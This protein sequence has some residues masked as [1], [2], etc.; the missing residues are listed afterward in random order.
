VG[1]EGSG[2]SV[3]DSARPSTPS[4]SVLAKQAQAERIAAVNIWRGQCLDNFARIEHA[5]I[6]CSERLLDRVLQKTFT[7]E[8]S[9]GNRTR[10]LREALDSNWPKN[11]DAHQLSNLLDHWSIREKERNNLVHGRFSIRAGVNDGWLLVNEL[12]AVKKGVALG[13][14]HTLDSRQADA[15]LKAI[16][17][18]RKRLE[19]ALLGFSGA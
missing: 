5:I 18:E 7:L 10:K 6:R 4:K 14:R 16:I 9:A 15:F 17:D 12:L 13:S 2:L 19:E 11:P 8:E 1:G 3:T